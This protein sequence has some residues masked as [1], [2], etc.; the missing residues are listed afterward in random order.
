MSDLG[1]VPVGFNAIIKEEYEQTG[2]VP[3]GPRSFVS[4]PK[5]E[6]YRSPK[7]GTIQSL[8]GT[9][10]LAS[11]VLYHLFTPIGSYAVD[12]RKGSYLEG[13]VGSNFDRASLTVALVRAIQK[14]EDEIRSSTEY[15]Y[16]PNP[17]EELDSIKVANIEF[18]NSDEVIISLSIKAQ[19]G[20]VAAL[21]VGV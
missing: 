17:D 14:V 21:Q 15:I 19:S 1:V 16:S 9:G 10:L 5:F 2:S 6:F 3:S 13:L 12:T 4:F 20:L 8:D 11:K 18:I 7:D